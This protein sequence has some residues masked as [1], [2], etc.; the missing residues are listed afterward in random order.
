MGTKIKEQLNGIDLQKAA[1]EIVESMRHAVTKV[2][3][4]KGAVLGISGGIDS[5]VTAALCVR[6]FG[7]ERVLALTMP[8]RHSD[9]ETMPLCKILI[10]HFGLTTVHEDIT[11]ILFAAKCYE[12]QHD[13]VR[14][15]LPEFGDDW[16]FKIV[17][18]SVVDTEQLRFFSVV[19]E[20]PNGQTVSARL[21]VSA[22]L[23]LV[24][25]TNFKQRVRKMLEYYHADRLNF[26]VFGTPNR[27]EYDQGFFVKNGDG[28]SDMKPIAHLYKSQVYLLAEYLG[29][30]L[31]IRSR[32]PTTDTYSL[33]Q[34]QEEFYFSLSYDKM[35]ICM[36]GKNHGVSAAQVAAEIGLSEQQVL[37][38][39]KDIDQKRSTTKYQHLRPQTV[40]PI[41]EIDV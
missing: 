17:L 16:K 3:R 8:E 37:R 9:N 26:A 38:V 24:A 7:P 35:D 29:V 13:A 39:F 40:E 23:S 15:A 41:P 4:R 31:E 25:A 11:E 19:A 36:Y 22:Y 2:F 28:A 10:D 5:S 30:P 32:P 34:S 21:P 18:P 12:R 14:Q 20:Q 33:P 27:L 6:A 1:D